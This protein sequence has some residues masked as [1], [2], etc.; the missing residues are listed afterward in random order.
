MYVTVMNTFWC[1]DLADAYHRRVADSPSVPSNLLLVN[2]NLQS[3]LQS[4]TALRRL[5]M[6]FRR[7]P[8]SLRRKKE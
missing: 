7:F 2:E 5:Y 4:G 3:S 8:L 1:A 6:D